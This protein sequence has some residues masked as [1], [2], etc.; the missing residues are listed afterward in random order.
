VNENESSL[1]VGELAHAGLRGVIA[2]M[3]MSGMR[4]CT[5]SLGLVKQTPPQAI[6]R[7]RARFLLWSIP[8][9]R[10]RAVEELTHWGY[11]A[12]GGVTYG[13][14]PDA[15]RRR[16]WSGPI[17]GLALWLGFELGVAPVLGLS[18][19]RQLRAV[20]RAALAADHLLYGLVLSETHSRPRE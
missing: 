17:Y 8:R 4:A 5:Q 1:G 13:A 18:Q 19:S 15:L 20:E 9:K 10:R 6:F 2:A 3:A 12:V 14:L 11:G 7:Q 16:L